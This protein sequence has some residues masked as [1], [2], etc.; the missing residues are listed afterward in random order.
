MCDYIILRE[1]VAARFQNRL[2]QRINLVSNLYRHV[3]RGALRI[4]P[5]FFD[6]YNLIIPRALERGEIEIPIRR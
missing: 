1:L 6:G 2:S 4:A 3:N 5:G